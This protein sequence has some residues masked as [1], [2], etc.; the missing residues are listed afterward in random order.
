MY[1]KLWIEGNQPLRLALEKLNTQAIKVLV[2]HQDGIL[3]GT[4]T[5]GDVRRYLLSGGSL[6]DRVEQAAFRTPMTVS[7]KDEGER[8]IRDGCPH[9][10]IPV[11]K[12]DG[13]L[14]GIVVAKEES[15]AQTKLNLPVVIMAGGKG[16]RLYPY[17]KI[18]PK[19]LIPVGDRPILEHIM[20]RFQRV[21]CDDFHLIVNHKRELIKAYFNENDHPYHL[22]WYDEEQPLG[23]GGGLSLLKGKLAT[24]FFLINCDIL[25]MSVNMSF[26]AHPPI[27]L[28]AEAAGTAG[29]NLFCDGAVAK[30][31]TV[32]FFRFPADCS[33][34]S[35][36]FVS[37]NHRRI[38]PAG[39]ELS[40]A[41]EHGG[42]VIALR[43]AG[44]DPAGLY[45]NQN[46]VFVNRRN[47]DLFIT[48]IIWSVAHNGIHYC[49]DI[50]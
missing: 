31:Q 37:G 7:T 1:K 42:S 21:G 12:E 44:A 3:V 30:I 38:I 20:D 46:L 41:P 6:E 5:D 19:P 24:T 25:L 22:H 17:T 33:D 43:I 13:R 35:D 26:F 8:I 4:L 29:N 10:L 16:T 23:T 27:S 49:G 9:V 36:E 40:V 15:E 2:V 48:I 14:T 11:V 50:R 39:Q 45:L 47:R 28:P 18:L 32:L 34:G